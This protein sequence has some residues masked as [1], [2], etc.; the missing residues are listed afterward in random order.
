MYFIACSV[1]GIADTMWAVFYFTGANPESSVVIMTLYACTNL[2][3]LASLMAFTVLQF[4]KWNIL[5]YIA[6]LLVISLLTAVLVWIVVFKKDNH[7]LYVMLSS[8]YTSVFSVVSDVLI[9]VSVLTLLLTVRSGKYSA[10]IYLLAAGILLFP[11]ID[12]AYYYLFFNDLY[13]PNTIIDFMYMLTLNLIALACL[14]MTNKADQIKTWTAISNV[15]TRKTWL[16][17]LM[18]PLITSV[19]AVLKVVDDYSVKDISTFIL[20]ILIYIAFNKYIQLN[21]ELQGLLNIEKEMNEKLERRV[22]EQIGELTFLANQD[23]LTGLYNRKYFINTL[24][25]SIRSQRGKE[26]L[27]LVLIDVDRFKTINDHYNHYVGDKI[28]IDIS[29]RMIEWNNYGAVLARLGGDEFAVIFQGK[30][31]QKDIEELCSQIIKLCGKPV[32]CG[33]YELAVTISMGIALFSENAA[34]VNTLLKN[35]DI[36]MYIAKSQGYNK[37]HFYNE[38][39]C[40]AI[41][42]QNEIEVLLRQTDIDK[43][44]ELF[45]QPMF[46]LPD[47]KLVGAEALVRWKNPIYGYIS[48]GIFIPVAERSDYI[49][50]I[51]NWVMKKAVE[52]ASK[53]NSTYQ[54]LKVSFNISPKQLKDENFISGIKQLTGMDNVN[55]SW[56]EAEITESVMLESE[57]KVYG[58]LELLKSVG[59]SISVDDFGSGYSSLGYLNNYPFNK[60]KIDKS[61]IDNLSAY[62]KTGNNIVKAIIDIA[63]ATGIYTVAEGVETQEQLEI[64]IELGCSQ[65]QGFLLGRPAPAESFENRF[66]SKLT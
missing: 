47:K 38:L 9:F 39:T 64:L 55:T 19:L 27:A 43:E 53:W 41:N 58:M 22:A 6:D 21:M 59:I 28:L 4:N 62:N 30:Y 25:N 40:E 45:F 2:M 61:L 56:L 57:Y 13:I 65:V 20:I 29:H 32:D 11:V 54:P 23:T 66:L 50:K 44:L 48:P 31:G 42:H 49:F 46:S 1:W 3:L 26:L 63:S 17:L 12:A 15:G 7:L 51:G 33:Q 52:Q 14:W 18:F 16:C 10:Y 37:Y 35:A 24:E 36:A 8:D 34:D 60:I 5:Q